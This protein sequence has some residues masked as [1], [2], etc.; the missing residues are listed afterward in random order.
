MDYFFPGPIVVD[1]NGHT[2]HT[3]S[4]AGQDLDVLPLKK[5]SIPYFLNPFCL[6]VLSR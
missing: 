4:N 5:K 3:L 6:A 1:K 2:V